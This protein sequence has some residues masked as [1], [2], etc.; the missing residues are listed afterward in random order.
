MKVSEVE[1]IYKKKESTANAKK[2]D[3][4]KI[5]FDILFSL[6]DKNKIDYVEH[7]YVLYINRANKVIGSILLSTGGCI[8]T[9]VDVKVLIQGAILSNAQAIIIAH[10]HPS[11]SL[12]PSNM[13]LDIT[14]RIKT[15]C[16]YFEI[17]LLDHIIIADNQYYSFKDEGRL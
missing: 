3:T 17:S 8:G 13:D 14:T 4:S 10:N 15:A 5:A 7:F 16:N 1:L 11:G 9:V 6:W 12:I 2:I